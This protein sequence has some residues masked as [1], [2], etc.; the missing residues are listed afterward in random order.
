[1]KEI[2]KIKKCILGIIMLLIP[3]V[4]IAY[5]TLRFTILL[6]VITVSALIVIYFGFAVYLTTAHLRRK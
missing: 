3:V 1:M 2:N 4:V 5:F 6:K